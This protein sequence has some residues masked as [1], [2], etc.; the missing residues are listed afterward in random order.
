MVST[1]KRKT[2]WQLPFQYCGWRCRKTYFQ[3]AEGVG[4]SL[5]RPNKSC[6]QTVLGVWPSLPPDH[7]GQHTLPDFFIKPSLSYPSTYKG[8]PSIHC[9]KS[10]LK[11]LASRMFHHAVPIIDSPVPSFLKGLQLPLRQVS[12]I[13]LRASPPDPEPR[14]INRK[15]YWPK[16][17]RHGF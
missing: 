15:K 1:G 9:I 16:L 2:R 3:R 13:W 17:R 8:S 7:T 14:G 12:S 5:I 4:A 11:C 10:K 6:P